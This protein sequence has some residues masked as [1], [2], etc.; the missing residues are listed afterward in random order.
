MPHYYLAQINIGRILGA[1]DSPV[2][3]AFMAR[4]AEINALAEQSPGFVWRLQTAEGDATSLRPCDDP[5]MLINVSVWESPAALK[6]FSYQTDHA[7]LLRRR[8]DW[9]E[10][11]TQKHLALWWIPAGHIP[12]A[13]EAV[14]R[15]EFL[16]INGPTPIAFTFAESFPRWD[17]PTGDGALIETGLNGKRLAAMVRDPNGDAGSDTIFR[18]RQS[19][20]RV[21]A[22]YD[23]GRVRF[24]ALTG[25]VTP[26]GRLD[27]RYHHVDPSGEIRTGW[28][29]GTPV[30]LPDGRL[31]LHEEWQWTNGNCQPGRSVLEQLPE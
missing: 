16:R 30:R 7:Q 28:C 18:Y 24:G 22:L 3:A 15:L 29:R 13:E 4:L 27:I 10:R 6:A 1:T 31:R 17:E 20:P 21:W 26:E 8:T 14:A 9:F 5:M 25:I 11:P 23:G 2:M 12:T 19:G